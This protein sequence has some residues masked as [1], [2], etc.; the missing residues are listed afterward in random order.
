MIQINKF[1]ERNQIIYKVIGAIILISGKK[2]MQKLKL[3]LKI[4]TVE[5]SIFFLDRQLSVS[6]NAVCQ[7]T[8]YSL[9][10]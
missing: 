2:N 6:E 10:V 8:F 9:L 5:Y 4:R 7:H 1:T 3:E